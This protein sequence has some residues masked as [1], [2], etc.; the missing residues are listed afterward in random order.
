[1]GV[2]QLIHDIKPINKTTARPGIVG[3]VG[4]VV[5]RPRFRQSTPSMA[6][7]YDPYWSATRANTLGSNVSDGDILGYDSRGGPART[8]DSNW[9]GNRSFKH[10]YGWTFHA[11]RN[12]DKYSEPELTPLGAVSW[13]LKQARSR[14]IKRSGKL[15][16]VLPQGYQPTP[17]QLLRG[18]AYP[19][20]DTA[21]GIEPAGG[22]GFGATGDNVVGGTGPVWD[23][24]L[25][26][27]IADTRAGISKLGIQGSAPARNIDG[28]VSATRQ[29]L[30]K[31]RMF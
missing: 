22:G 15:F 26:A 30:A 27:D 10:Q 18:G 20:Q 1:M 21:G 14:I 8:N 28:A 5:V 3:S 29:Q 6:W 2:G 9:G 7:A 25:D 16:S 24:N 13:K 4:D 17:G 31:L 11:A 23:L 12:T 19:T